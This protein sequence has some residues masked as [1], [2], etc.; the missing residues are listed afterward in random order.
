MHCNMPSAKG[1]GKSGSSNNREPLTQ[2]LLNGKEKARTT[3][4]SKR[5]RAYRGALK[6]EEREVPKTRSKKKEMINSPPDRVT[7]S[8]RGGGGGCEK[9]SG[10]KRNQSI[11]GEIYLW[12]SFIN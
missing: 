12:Q 10:I 1:A 5:I 8:K 3:H 7:G 9:K 2:F 4:K 11:D 6:K